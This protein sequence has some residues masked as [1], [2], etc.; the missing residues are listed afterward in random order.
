MT[1]LYVCLSQTLQYLVNNNSQKLNQ[2]KFEYNFWY[3]LSTTKHTHNKLETGK[4]PIIARE[5]EPYLEHLKH[6]EQLQV[7]SFSKA[8]LLIFQHLELHLHLVP[9]ISKRHRS[10]EQRVAKEQ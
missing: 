3:L 1:V 9:K 8:Y 7:L 2:I 6:D 5:T 10:F 4:K